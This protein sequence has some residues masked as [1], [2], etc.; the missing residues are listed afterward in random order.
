MELTAPEYRDLVSQ[1]Y[2]QHQAG[3]EV[4]AYEY[5]LIKKD[6][7]K[8]YTV[9][10]TKLITYHGEQAI[11]GIVTDIT[12]RKM[13]ETEIQRI[14][15]ELRESN[16][17]KD[18]FFSIIAHDLR[19]P[20]SGLLGL[21]EVIADPTEEL[22]IQE[23]R[24]YSARLHQLLRNQFNLLQNLLE[25]SRLQRGGIDF[26]PE[27][28]NLRSCISNVADQLAVNCIRKNINLTY[29]IESNLFV[30]ADA[31]M[32]QSILLNLITNAIKFTQ[33]NG[34][35]KVGSMAFDHTVEVFVEDSGVG[36]SKERLL[37]IFK[38]EEVN[39]TGGTDG[40][41]GTGLGLI[42]CKE[43]IERHVGTI[44][45]ESELGKGSK[46]IFTLPKG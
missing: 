26:N 39:S 11:L 37:S 29:E 14:N 15:E 25:W 1:K 22:T 27:R 8:T 3:I 41:K 6:G 5:A 43:F 36:I 21:S 34:Q 2:K 42:L 9:L 19:S 17:A 40:E 7:R 16:A 44:H 30:M 4:E 31:D 28:L 45:A 12:G 24:K 10:N 13:M 46:F 18:K 35:I 20:F 23:M 33:K 32:L 38:L